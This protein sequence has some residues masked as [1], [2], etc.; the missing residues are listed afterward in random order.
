MAPSPHKPGNL[1][2][3]SHELPSPRGRAS[4]PS[5]DRSP[6][7][8]LPLGSPLLR[9]LQHRRP[10]PSQSRG[11]AAPSSTL[12]RPRSR[13]AVHRR[14]SNVA[15]HGIIVL[16]SRRPC[17][18]SWQHRLDD[19]AHRTARSKPAPH[20]TTPMTIWQRLPAS[21]AGEDERPRSTG[22]FSNTQRLLQHPASPSQQCCGEAFLQAS[23]S[24]RR[25][26]TARPTRSVVWR[27]S[28]G[29][30]GGASPWLRACSNSREARKR[31][32][33]RRLL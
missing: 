5:R 27:H 25:C 3:R 24:A 26:S 13:R 2:P 29:H 31:N 20:I 23:V 30:G 16:L 12:A 18:T 10:L 21:R 19:T 4:P 15:A 1:P 22:V 17:N 32:T 6:P 33:W 8:S 7:S 28:S 11:V 14:R 9:G